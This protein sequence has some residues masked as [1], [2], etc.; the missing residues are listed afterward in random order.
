MRRMCPERKNSKAENKVRFYMYLS[1]FNK[2][3]EAGYTHFRKNNL[4][5]KNTSSLYQLLDGED[6]LLIFVLRHY[7]LNIFGALDCFSGKTRHSKTSF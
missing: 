7:K 3:N 2:L 1:W 5:Y 6:L 4:D